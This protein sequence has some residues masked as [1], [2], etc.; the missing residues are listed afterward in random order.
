MDLVWNWIVAASIMLGIILAVCGFVV[1][2]PVYVVRKELIS[3]LISRTYCYLASD[4][5]NV[6]ERESQAAP[7]WSGHDWKF[8]KRASAWFSSVKR[9]CVEP[10]TNH[11][12]NRGRYRRNRLS[13]VFFL[14]MTSTVGCSAS[15]VSPSH[16][17]NPYAEAGL[18]T[19]WLK[20]ELGLPGT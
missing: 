7:K 13:T 18:D 10:S 11:R 1:L 2:A 9:L 16:V 8:F 12:K 17:L 14:T 15:D 4:S 3:K 19:I 6:D 5:K 20:E